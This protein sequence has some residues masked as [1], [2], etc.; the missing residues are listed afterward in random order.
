MSCC[1][2]RSRTT[3]LSLSLSFFFLFF[4]LW[5]LLFFLGSTYMFLFTATFVCCRSSSFSLWQA[6]CLSP[7]PPPP[8]SFSLDKAYTFFLSFSQNHKVSDGRRQK[9]H[10]T[11]VGTKS[12]TLRF[13]SQRTARIIY[14]LKMVFMACDS[15]VVFFFFLSYGFQF[16]CCSWSW[17]TH[18]FYTLVNRATGLADPDCCYLHGRSRFIDDKSA[19]RSD[20]VLKIQGVAFLRFY[21]R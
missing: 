9:E 2:A 1:A 21:T 5:L 6:K 8:C 7:P 16:I 4:S 18:I 12:T 19:H 13:L 11:L 10:G 15:W 3:S 20:G 14:C 17:M